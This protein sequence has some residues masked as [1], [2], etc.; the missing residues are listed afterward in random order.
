MKIYLNLKYGSENYT[1]QLH[2]EFFILFIRQ[3]KGDNNYESRN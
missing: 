2:T 1:E 3:E